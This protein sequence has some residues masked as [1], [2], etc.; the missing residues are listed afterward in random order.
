MLTDGDSPHPSENA[1][2]MTLA[3]SKV[4]FLP[5]MSLT[6]VQMDMK[7]APR[8]AEPDRES[9]M[10]FRPVNVIRNPVT[11][12]LVLLKPSRSLVIAISEVLTIVTSKLTKKRQIT[13]LGPIFVFSQRSIKWP[14]NRE[15]S[16][17]KYNKAQSPPVWK[18]NLRPGRLA[19]HHGDLFL[20]LR[21]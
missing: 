8:L 15:Y 6:L 12:Q 20:A 7:P 5:M 4:F 10:D 16:I 13:S 1:K 2:K 14:G 3:A 18:H 17:P 11:I 21:F 9:N 19:S